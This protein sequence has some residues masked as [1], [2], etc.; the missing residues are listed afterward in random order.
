MA[1]LKRYELYEGDGDIIPEKYTPPE[2]R[3]ETGEKK[4]VSPNPR[5]PRN[6]YF[7]RNEDDGLGAS[8]PL[9]DDF[10]RFSSIPELENRARKKAP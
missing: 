7:A 4:P 10:D 9:F 8:S 1:R 3:E 2:E 5:E 6:R